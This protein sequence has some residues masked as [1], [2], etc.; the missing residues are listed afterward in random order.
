[1][2]RHRQGGRHRLHGALSL[3][4]IQ[5]PLPVRDPGARRPCRPREV[6][7]CD[8]GARGFRGC[9]GRRAQRRLRADRPRGPAQPCAGGRAGARR[10]ASHVGARGGVAPGGPLRDA[11]SRV[12]LG[13]L[14]H[15]RDGAG[16][17]SP[18]RPA[19]ALTRHSRPLQQRLA[20]VSP[21]RQ[22]LARRGARVLRR[23]LPRGRRPAAGRGAEGLP[24][25]ASWPSAKPPRNRTRPRSS[26]RPRSG[27]R[28][29][30]HRRAAA[31]TKVASGAPSMRV[32]PSTSSTSPC[33]D[34]LS[35]WCVQLGASRWAR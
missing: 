35:T 25:S 33:A 10:P 16:R 28:A 21:A 19:P 24:R 23:S 7:A 1:M 31:A 30:K 20:L 5:A 22:P 17:H 12:R 32:S 14:P 26:G 29:R 8:R 4:R 15:A 6:R 13:D 3:L 27:P 18:G 34:S 9:A 11:R 2:G